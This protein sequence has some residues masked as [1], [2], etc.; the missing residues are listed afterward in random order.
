MLH[1]ALPA[2]RFCIAPMLDRTDRHCRALFRL[3]TRNALV[4]T[5]MVTTG[6]LLHGDAERH[7][8]F[9]PNEHP[10]A[11]QLGGSDP[12][13]LAKC[14]LLAAQR[15]YD[16]VNL[17]CGC[18]SDRVQAGRF[19][20]C[21]MREPGLVADCV[22]AMTGAVQIPVTVKCRIGVDDQD[23]YAA[24]A[25]FVARVSAAG[26]RRFVIHARK[27]WLQ[28]LSPR[29]NREI[30]PLNYP[31]VYRLKA[32]FPHLDVVLNGGLNE[33]SKAAAQLD[34]V[35]GVMLGRAV[36]QDPT[37]LRA[38]DPILFGAA[39]ESWAAIHARLRNHLVEELAR[40]TPL[41]RM[42][43]HLLGLHQGQ[44][45]ARAFRRL[46]STHATRAGATIDVWDAALARLIP[47]SQANERTGTDP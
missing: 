37:L 24:L 27:A 14:A 6:A 13:D 38:V 18:P 21:L 31:V 28:G 10:V 2:H 16:E 40:G 4:Y 33:L 12:D 34:R 46:L 30:P 42:V 44:P 11:F 45:G 41:H 8:A 17:N 20:A 35:D 3:L 47:L 29:E 7:L 22:A 23:D 9:D 5:E 1:P 32:D 19:G 15:G 26:C 39:T 25:G 36:Y 43:R